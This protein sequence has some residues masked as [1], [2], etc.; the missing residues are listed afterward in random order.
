MSTS[1]SE[2]PTTTSSGTEN[3]TVATKSTTRPASGGSLSARLLARYGVLFLLLVMVAVYTALLPDMFFTMANFRVISSTQVVL[4][5][6]VLGL[7][8]PYS[9]GEFDMSF[10]AVIA[11]SATLTAVLTAKAGWAVGPTLIVVIASA[12]GWGLINAFFI[13]RVGISSLITTLGTGTVIIGLTLA[14]SNSQVIGNVPPLLSD[15]ATGQLLGLPY[16]VYAVVI[17]V[18]LFAI[19]LE[20][21]PLG[22]YLYFTGEGR[23]VARLS[24]LPVDRLRTGAL[25][26]CSAICGVAGVLSYARLGSADPNLGMS[27]LLPG[28]A[29]V[30][31]GATVIKPGRFNAWGSMIAVLLLV[32]GV[33]GLQMLGGAGWL[34]NVFNGTALVLA[35]TFAHLMGKRRAI[36]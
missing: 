18:V 36:A 8:L 20:H 32:T 33:S 30:F 35:V 29:A 1:N 19:L 23:E 14:I 21:T 22:R 11:W 27:F 25:V 10:G 16:P 3:S 15:I 5:I 2:V 31:L 12:I 17:L 7:L 28:T 6:A 13:V 4:L 9:A 24:G 34:E 26:A